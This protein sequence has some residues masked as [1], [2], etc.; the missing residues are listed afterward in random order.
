MAQREGSEH[1]ADRLQHRRHDV[2]DAFAF[3]R[4]Q[5]RHAVEEQ[6]QPE[7]IEQPIDQPEPGEGAGDREV[8][9]PA[10]QHVAADDQR[11]LLHRPER[12]RRLHRFRTGH[13]PRR[14][15]RR[16][17]HR[18]LHQPAAHHERQDDRDQQEH[19]EDHELPRLGEDA[20]RQAAALVDEERQDRAGREPDQ[21]SASA[22]ADDAHEERAAHEIAGDDAETHQAE[23]AAL[24]EHQQPREIGC[25]HPRHPQKRQRNEQRHQTDEP[26]DSLHPLEQ[27]LRRA[28]D[29][30]AHAPAELGVVLRRLAG[31]V[32]VARHRLLKSA[33][34]DRRG[35][36][37]IA[38]QAGVE[39][40]HVRERA[41]NVPSGHD[42]RAIDAREVDDLGRV[43]R[44]LNV[45][46]VLVR[47]ADDVGRDEPGRD[48]IE[49]REDVPLVGHQQ[50]CTDVGHV[51]DGSGLIHQPAIELVAIEADNPVDRRVEQEPRLILNVDLQGEVARSLERE[52]RFAHRVLRADEREHGAALLARVPLG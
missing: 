48:L 1:A 36:L 23:R 43:L 47:D 45:T 10:G 17:R 12:H 8:E 22:A 52:E 14:F 19:A 24:V 38:V 30:E 13:A 20:R 34:R 29:D 51:A 28:V 21:P 31:F 42:A 15:E 44:H 4:H 27:H 7:E 16:D 32:A 5:R 49:L 40:F 11:E 6:R 26:R 37:G 50:D 25:E 3:G 2:L 39:R 33:L 46:G 18:V 9:N 35:L 41:G